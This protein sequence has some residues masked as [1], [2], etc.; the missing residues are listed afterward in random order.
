MTQPMKVFFPNIDPETGKID[1]SVWIEGKRKTMDA[2]TK[3]EPEGETA[4][5]VIIEQQK[6]QISEMEKRL[7][8]LTEENDKLKEEIESLKPTEDLTAQFKAGKITAGQFATK[9][10]NL[11]K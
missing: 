3:P 2:P 6:A 4:K 5:D 9:L 8:R 7:K 1:N 11:K 10:K